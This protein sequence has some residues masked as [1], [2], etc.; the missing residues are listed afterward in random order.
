MSNGLKGGK[1]AEKYFEKL[2]GMEVDMSERNTKKAQD[3]SKDL[4]ILRQLERALVTTTTT[5]HH[6]ETKK[7]SL[8]PQ[9]KSNP[10]QRNN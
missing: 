3:I 4:N 7:I 1:V 5:T 10:K 8:T 2:I 9:P 6:K